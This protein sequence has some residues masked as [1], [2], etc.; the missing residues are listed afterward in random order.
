[1]VTV[2]ANPNIGYAF[3]NWSGDLSGSVNPT[4]ITMNGNKSVTANFVSVPTYTLTTSATNGSITLNPPGGV[5]TTG[6]V[7]TVTANPNTGYAFGNWSGDLSG[8]VNPTT[9]TMNGNKSV[10]ANFSVLPPGSQN[11][12]F[13]VGD[14]ASNWGIGLG[15]S[16]PPP[17]FRLHRAGGQRR[18]GNGWEC[19]RQGAGPHLCDRRLRH[20]R[21]ESSGMWRCQSSIGNTLLQDDFG[22]TTDQA[23]AHAASQTNLNITNP[24][25]PL[26]AGLPA[27]VRTVATVA[28]DFSWGEPGGSP[29]IIAR[30]N[31]GSNHPCLYAYEAGCG[32]D[33]RH[34]ARTAGSSVPAKRYVRLVER[35]RIEAVRRG[36]QL[37]GRSASVPRAGF[38]PPVLQGGQ[39]R[40]EWVGGTLQTATNLAGP[41]SDLSGAVSPY[42]LPT[43]NSAQFFRVKQ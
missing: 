8:S 40:L 12:L 2:T 23:L 10:T 17:E 14:A 35:R 22:F 20:R 15:D 39:L 5:Y 33:H 9:I 41:W 13:V 1:M 25:H 37:G 24:G 30:L 7:V 34:G 38:Q 18:V 28:G 31:D 16:Q 29:I 27:G 6:T 26:A 32:D 19:H 43:T 11:V 4:N 36:R 42:L 21:R 3:A